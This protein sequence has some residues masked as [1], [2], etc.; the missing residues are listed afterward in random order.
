MKAVIKELHQRNSTLERELEKAKSQNILMEDED[1]DEEQ[2]FSVAEEDQDYYED[3][4]DEEVSQ[5]TLK[6]I[7]DNSAD[8]DS[9]TGPKAAKQNV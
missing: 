7:K 6:E 5:S 8:R 2:V 4:S 1:D 3:E 9:S